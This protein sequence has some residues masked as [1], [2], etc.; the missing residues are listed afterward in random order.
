LYRKKIAEYIMDETVIKVGSEFIWLWVAIES[1]NKGILGIRVIKGERGRER[2]RE[3]EKYV[4][5]RE[6]YLWFNQNI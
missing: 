1:C 6:V 5:C 3:E 2:E 4:C